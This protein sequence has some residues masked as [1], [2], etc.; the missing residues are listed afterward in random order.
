MGNRFLTMS[1]KAFALQ[2]HLDFLYKSQPRRLSSRARTLSEFR[3]WRQEL[4]SEILRLLG[5][6]GREL[7]PVVAELVQTIDRGL[8]CEEK[9]S[10]KV[11]EQVRTPMYVLVPKR[12]PP[13]KPI[14]AFHGHYPSVRYILGDYPDAET[15]R[16]QLAVDNNYAQT[17]A[18]AGYL[19]CAIEQRGFGERKTQDTSGGPFPRSCRHLSF[20][21]MLQGR[22]LIG[23]RCW[24]GICAINYLKTRSDVVQDVLGCTG[25]SGG[26]CTVLWLSAIDPRITVSV[27]ASYFCSFK[28]SILSQSH[29]ECNY[30]PGILAL[31]EM[32]DLAAL[33]APRP[34]RAINGENDPI[35][36]VQAAAS[37]FETVKRAYALH[38]AL[39]AC[40]LAIHPGAH[41]YHHQL[42][43]DWFSKWL[44]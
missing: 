4:R 23:E 7:P 38:D 17:L 28:A 6:G 16:E 14:L 22:T 18:Q 41:A 44:R 8:Y 1:E 25:H 2:P 20:E 43:Q 29:C 24:D 13:F 31:A 12:E 34:F 37:Q 5:I 11:G 27:P 26:G 33:I 9:Y 39:D 35:F 36:P 40:S 19:V 3:Q 30:V 42:S 10:L 21:Y 32:G 15:A